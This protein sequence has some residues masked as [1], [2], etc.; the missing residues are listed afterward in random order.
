MWGNKDY[1]IALSSDNIE[2]FNIVPL[3]NIVKTLQ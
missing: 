1:V 2:G 3:S